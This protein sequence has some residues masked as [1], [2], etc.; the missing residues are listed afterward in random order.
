MQHIRR[1]GHRGGAVADQL[2][3][4]GRGA[5]LHRARYR[6]H[7]DRA[8]ERLTCCGER[9]TSLTTLDD[10]EHLAECSEDAVAQREPELLGRRAR[11]PLRQQQTVGSDRPPQFGVLARVRTVEPVGDH[12]DGVPRPGAAQGAAVG[13]A[14]DA[15]G[16]PGH[17]DDVGGCQLADR[18]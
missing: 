6:H 15:L 14:I 17:D 5:G 2:V 16:Q 12:A 4:A 7:L 1:I 9:S 11:W 3:G 8:L 13:R 18:A 10:D